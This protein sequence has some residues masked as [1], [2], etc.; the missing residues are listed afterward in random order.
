[1]S[2]DIETSSVFS[3]YTGNRTNLKADGKTIG[4]CLHDLA[5]QYPDFGELILEKNGG[6]S[7]SFD[8]FVNGKSVYPHTMTRPVKDGDKLYIVML[9]HG[10]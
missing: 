2:I 10:G 1:M 8:V 6:L 3:R 7:P 4:E 5:G 9:V